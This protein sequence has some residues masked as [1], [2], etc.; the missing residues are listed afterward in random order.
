MLLSVCLLQPVKW[1]FTGERDA[2]TSQIFRDCRP[3]RELPVGD[4]IW[5]RPLLLLVP[6]CGTLISIY[7]LGWFQGDV[8]Q[9]QLT[10][11]KSGRSR[12]HCRPS[13][14]VRVEVVVT[15]SCLQC[16]NSAIRTVTDFFA[17]LHYLATSGLVI[18]RNKQ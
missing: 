1:R 16:S 7:G 9:L 5:P 4:V 6:H 13:Q 10:V 11:S 17:E 12:D 8:I 3:R 15:T 18:V 2:P 14:T